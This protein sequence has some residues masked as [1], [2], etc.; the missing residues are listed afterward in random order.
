M[1][2]TWEE[3]N[4]LTGDDEGRVTITLAHGSISVMVMY[5][6]DFRY[7]NLRQVD[8]KY[9]IEEAVKNTIERLKKELK[10]EH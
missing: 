8:H 3:I 9:D 7:T 4:E 5:D 10:G 1:L 6:D 2:T